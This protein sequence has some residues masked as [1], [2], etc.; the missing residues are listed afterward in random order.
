[1][2]EKDMALPYTLDDIRPPNEN[3]IVNNFDFGDEVGELY[4]QTLREMHIARHQVACKS[5]ASLTPALQVL[6]YDDPA[7]LAARLQRIGDSIADAAETENTDK[8]RSRAW[9]QGMAL[10]HFKR[11]D[12]NL[13]IAITV[14]CFDL[15]IASKQAELDATL[16][17]RRNK[18][19]LVTGFMGAY[20]KMA[21]ALSSGTFDKHN[22]AQYFDLADEELNML[23]GNQTI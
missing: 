23:K 12:G 3:D 1:M 4:Y 13:A 22:V 21:K 14:P 8:W 7:N 9:Y 15:L 16:M 2:A 18:N 19:E 5:H 17:G 20:S 6:M 10:A 11:P